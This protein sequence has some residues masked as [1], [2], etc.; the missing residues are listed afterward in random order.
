VLI[1]RFNEESIAEAIRLCKE[2]LQIDPEFAG[3]WAMLAS[4]HAER[5]IWGRPPSSRETGASARA[6]ITRALALDPVNPEAM[7]ILG[8]IS[9]VYDWDFVAAERALDRAVEL[10]SA[11][12]PIRNLR[13]SLYQALRRFPEAVADA[14]VNRRL[15]PASFLAL[16]TLG[17][18]RY[19]AGM[20]NEAIDAYKQSIALDPGYAA[21]YARLADVYI[22][23]GN[24]DE[25][26]ATI[27][28]GPRLPGARRRQSDGMAVAHALAGRRGEAEKIRRDLVQISRDEDSAFY[29]L[30]MVDTAL[31][32]HDA[33]FGWLNR[34]FEA[35]SATLWLV[36]GEPKLDALRA[37]PRF[38]DLL[39]RMN[40]PIQ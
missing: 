3:A 28:R 23:L 24:Y 38:T 39:R 2:A 30:A 21:N 11:G 1:T 17:R 26:V 12:A 16:S 31:G 32:N 20:F 35:R 9:M 6:A 36:N 25:A 13:S 19:R 15:D 37:D 14:E 18:T 29:S 22:A 7:S 8:M 10:A 4:A 27:E 40:Y 33:A 5:G 34:A